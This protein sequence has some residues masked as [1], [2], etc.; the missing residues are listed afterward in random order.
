MKMLQDFLDTPDQFSKH[1]RQYDKLHHVW[2]CP[3][4]YLSLVGSTILDIVYGYEALPDGDKWIALS[5][6]IVN[7]LATAAR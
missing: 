4:L 5:D 6:G 7:D 1:F 3:N 2:R